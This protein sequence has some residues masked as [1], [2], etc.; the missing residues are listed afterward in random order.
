M[1]IWR[2]CTVALLMKDFCAPVSN[3]VF[4]LLVLPVFRIRI[5][6]VGTAAGHCLSEMGLTN[7]ED[8]LD[9]DFPSSLSRQYYGN[10]PI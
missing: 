8:K 5:S 9:C 4:T 10:Y 3:K 7:V 1:G 2:F 6:A